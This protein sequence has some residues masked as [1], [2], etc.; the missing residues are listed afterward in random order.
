M[1]IVTTRDELRSAM[2][3]NSKS[4]FVPTM[5]ALHP[6]HVSL[7]TM[8][9]GISDVVVASIFV[10]PTQFAAGE[11][12]TEYPRTMEADLA[13]C[14]EAGVDVV[15]APSIDTMYPRGIGDIA[16]EP[17]PLG[18]VLEGGPRP[19]HFRG[20]LTVVAKLFGLVQP[21]VA[22]FGEKDYQ[23]LVLIRRMVA[24]LCMDIEVIGAPIV[25]EPD[26]LAMSS[27]NVY[28]TAEDRARAQFLY[29]ALEA[30]VAVETQG[31]QAVVTAAQAVLD[32]AG[33]IPDYLVVTD[34]ELGEPQAGADARLLVAAKVGQPRLLDNVPLTLGS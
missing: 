4:A 23:Q 11:D 6:G 13:A 25:R 9:R 1:R 17:G 18:S 15:F 16:V 19:T 14:E 30:G 33:I 31:P 34:T 27:R 7:M 28:L 22:I 3:E 32:S 21:R 12:F 8:A 10:N 20:V 29:Q 5:G 26:G 2:G 24:E